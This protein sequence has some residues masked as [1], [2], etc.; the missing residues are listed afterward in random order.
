[1]E[2]V[3]LEGIHRVNI[4]YKVW[5]QTSR[6][7]RKAKKENT[8]KQTKKFLKEDVQYEFDELIDS[9]LC[10]HPSELD[11]MLQTV[12]SERLYHLIQTYKD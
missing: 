5:R 12:K 6:S 3:Y 11:E 4:S 9:I 7:L 10:L 2:W 8:P 1:M